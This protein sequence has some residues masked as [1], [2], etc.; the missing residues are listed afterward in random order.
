MK[1]NKTTA[2]VMAIAGTTLLAGVVL[3]GTAI[4]AS[5]AE[6]DL[7]TVIKAKLNR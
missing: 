2:T 5:N 3:L 6:V 4:S 1:M 7:R